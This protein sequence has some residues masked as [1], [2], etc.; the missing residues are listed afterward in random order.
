MGR[1][2]D[3]AELAGRQHGVISRN[4]LL[5]L[6]VSDAT[7]SRLLARGWVR[8]HPG[9]Y[10]APASTPTFHQRVQAAQLA[11]GAPSVATGATAAHLY[12]LRPP[13]E[14]LTL[15][16]DE[17]ERAKPPAAVRLRR[18]RTL[19]PS[20]IA[21]VA[22]LQVATACRMIID[23]AAVAPPPQVRALIID[24][25]QR[26]LV[27]LDQIERRL[28]SMGPVPGR[29]VARRL[30]W[31]LSPVRCDSVLED[32][33]RRQLRD[34][35]L[36]PPDP[37]PVPVHAGGRMIHVDI[38]WPEAKV[39]IEVDGFAYHASRRDLDRD[40]RR[41]N[42]LALAGWIILRVGWDRLE[43]DPAAF[44]DEVGRLLAKV[45]SDR[46]HM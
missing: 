4:Q 30:V 26:R 6:G 15:L 35:G 5:A 23:F 13:P 44:T 42:A 7:T 38:G 16:V 8:L 3:V 36:P 12:G 10:R 45:W 34:A 9:V 33:T 25:R 41:A 20:D 2:Q 18:T 1:W 27:E 21:E 43:R 19:I 32:L 24:A 37:A 17:A 29:G 28:S 39:G 22:G 31:E 40:H 11:L 14:T 46:A